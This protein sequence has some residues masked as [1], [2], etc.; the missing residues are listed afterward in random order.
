MQKLQQRHAVC[1]YSPLPYLSS[2]Y[3]LRNLN[4]PYLNGRHHQTYT[5]KQDGISAL[6][7]LVRNHG[8]AFIVSELSQS[9]HRERRVFTRYRYL[10]LGKFQRN[11]IFSFP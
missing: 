2:L 10:L 4:E 5:K 3:R 11:V 6:R 7:K 9:L 8:G 1:T